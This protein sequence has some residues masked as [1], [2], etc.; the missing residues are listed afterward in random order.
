MPCLCWTDLLIAGRGGGV[1]QLSIAEKVLGVDTR[2]TSSVPLRR[3]RSPVVGDE[4]E[5]VETGVERSG[6]FQ[7][8][9]DDKDAV[10][11][12]AATGGP[13]KDRSENKVGADG[14]GSSRLSEL[15]VFCDALVGVG[16]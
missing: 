6:M 15:T 4:D 12:T 11:D 7:S 13:L 16:R 3:G 8:K 2:G 1:E 9:E 10:T 14:E 5:S